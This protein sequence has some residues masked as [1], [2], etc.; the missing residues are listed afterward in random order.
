MTAGRGIV[1]EE[2]HSKEFSREGGIFEMCQL[3][4]NLPKKY[5]LTKPKYQP[6][7]KDQIPTITLPL[8]ENSE[9]K[10]ATLATVRLISGD[11]DGTKG[12]AETF[13]PVQMWEVV[14]PDSGNEVDIPFP[15]DHNCIVFVRKGA[16]Q[17]LTGNNEKSSSLKRQDVAIMHIDG[18]KFLRIRADEA[19]TS[20][21]IMG[22]EPLNDPIVA[23]GPFVMNTRNEIQQAM[24]DYQSGRF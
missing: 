17:L 21:L 12:A 15:V 23:Q 3:W 20:L 14:F 6:I 7:L 24:V 9:G 18:S 11:L 4:V 2:Y 13:S 8:K 10:E 5:K 19:N 1:H 16:V 22:G